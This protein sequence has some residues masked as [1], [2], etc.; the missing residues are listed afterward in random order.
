MFRSIC[1]YC[2]SRRG[3]NPAYASAARSLG[4]HVAEAGLRL[5]YGGGGVGLMDEVAQAA[6]EAGGTV[7]G[8]IPEALLALEVGKHGIT[9][10]EVVRDMHARKHRMAALAD[11]FVALP[12]GYGTL[13][14]LFE[15]ITWTQLGVHRKPVGVLDV[16]GYYG[17][18]VSMLDHMVEEGFVSQAQRAIVAVASEPSDLLARMA[19]AVLP[20]PPRGPGPAGA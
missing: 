16:A 15:V 8:V 1:V 11:G 7:V 3:R 4:T 17:P 18:L 5:V 6:M 20:E 9:E 10:L 13:E 14:E 12:G 2:G 19:A